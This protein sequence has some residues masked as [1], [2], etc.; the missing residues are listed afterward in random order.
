VRSAV[1]HPSPVASR[2]LLVLGLAAALV[3]ATVRP[4]FAGDSAHARERYEQGAAAYNLGRFDDAIAAFS[5]AY[6]ED[7]A[8]ILLFNIAQS[9]WKKGDHEHAL[10]FYR[11]YLDADPRASNRATVEARIESLAAELEAHKP[12]PAPAPPLPPASGPPP[13][14]A[15]RSG[16]PD[17]TAG[18]AVAPVAVEAAATPAGRPVYQRAWFWGVVGAAV[19]G[20]AAVA[21][22]VASSHREAWACGTCSLGW[23]PVG[24][25]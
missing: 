20:A 19:I 22:A 4:S 3:L 16:T 10:F 25:H 24:G 8:P 18:R 21:V 7:H 9:H 11:R 23:V 1:I 13:T 2:L 17:V 15:A 14:E 6:E 12:A 5:D